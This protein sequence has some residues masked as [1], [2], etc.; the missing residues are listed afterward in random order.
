[1]NN[2]VIENW[3]ALYGAI[4][5]TIAL[6]I[7]FSRFIHTI[8]KEKVKLRVTAQPHQNKTENLEELASPDSRMLGGG[9]QQFLPIYQIKIS[10]VGNVDA[11]I[12]SAYVL[13][14]DGNKKH[15][16]VKYSHDQLRY[17]SI[18]QVGT[19]LVK[20][21]TSTQMSVYLHRGK[22]EFI[23]KAAEILD[24]NGKKW[25]AKM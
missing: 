7:N 22:A 2:W 17:G 14:D 3:L 15:V 5:G 6:V 12:E 19:I 11:H 10:N 13:T 8:G 16:L 21:K 18:D 20:P 4:V 23:A 9:Q 25:K 24:G 1:M